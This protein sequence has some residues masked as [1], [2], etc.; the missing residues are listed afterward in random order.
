M[1]AID[2]ACPQCG[3]KLK[4]PDSSML[5]RK[6]RCSKCG[7]GF[8]M[9]APELKTIHFAE[10]PA[11]PSVK[12]NFEFAEAD[13]NL[14]DD[15]DRTLVGVAV[16]FVPGSHPA[17]GPVPAATPAPEVSLPSAQLAT[18][19]IPSLTEALVDSHGAN[20]DVGEMSRLRKLR[21]QQAKRNRVVMASVGVIVALVAVVALY[22]SL[23][24]PQNKD[25]K[26]GDLPS[27]KTKRG[28]VDEE[29]A[30]GVKGGS[31]QPEKPGEQ[32]A[33]NFVPEGARIV[34]HL[35]PADLWQAEDSLEEFR[36]CLGP[37]GVWLERV[38]KERCLMDPAA[39]E[40]ALFA[41][42]PISRDSFEVAV[43]VH[44]KGQFK[45]SDLITKF[46]GELVDLPKPHYV[47]KERAWIIGDNRTFAGAP[48]AMAQ[49]LAESVDTPS[50]TADG[51]QALLS[52]TDRSRHF[53]LVCDLEDVRLGVKTLAPDNAQKFL[54]AIVDFFGDD[55]D[56]VCWSLQLGDAAGANDLKS[57]VLV[58]NK[59]SRTPA[60]LQGDL[61]KKLAQLPAD[62]LDLVKMARPKKIGEKK[63]IGRFPIMAK[64]VEQSTHF[65]TAHRVV[66]MKVELPER[67]GPNLALGTLLTWN[68]TTLPGFGSAPAATVAVA[69]KSNLPDKVADRLKKKITVDFRREFLYK[70]MEFIGEEIGVTIKLDGPSMKDV[71]V[72]Q[73]EY[74]T[75]AM[76]D[77]PAT[78]IL[79]KVLVENTKNKEF[80]NGKL[81]LIVDEEKKTATITGVNFARDRKQTS[82]PLEPASK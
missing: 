71:S 23:S 44:T 12:Q 4:L 18:S 79:H 8:I 35:R 5:G 29:D 3:R 22:A 80:P 68:Q 41:L 66:T 65:E 38:V 10:A 64:V 28:A 7:H 51:V 61:K 31:S 26:K 48:K 32:I 67:A 16:R 46:E 30:N 57:Q 15:S 53:T 17:A 21:Q 33:L 47:G 2:I 9:Q 74:Q 37:L 69:A 25:L 39:I 82:F 81:V 43:V 24:R 42:I 56:A 72:T 34:V 60:K 36:A 14:S 49:S 73:N 78:A 45:R 11:G 20:D 19:E 1:P 62:V 76:E 75:F 59:L 50:P 63:V 6:G 58:R 54:E 40:E 52:M 13:E 70:A 27:A 55:V 77:V